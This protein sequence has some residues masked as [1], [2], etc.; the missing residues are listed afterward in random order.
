MNKTNALLAVESYLA[1]KMKYSEFV[2]IYK[3]D[4]QVQKLLNFLLSFNKTWTQ[5]H[6]FFTDTDDAV[7]FIEEM[8]KKR[9]RELFQ[10]PVVTLSSAREYLKERFGVGDDFFYVNRFLE[11]SVRGEYYQIAISRDQ[12]E[13]IARVLPDILEGRAK[14]TELMYLVLLPYAQVVRIIFDI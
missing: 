5:A 13:I 3:N 10:N 8:L 7:L 4:E 11:C 9:K 2:E 6:F 1:S 14:I 12:L